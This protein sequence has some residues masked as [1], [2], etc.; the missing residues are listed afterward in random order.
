M[1][2]L[3]LLLLAVLI[4]QFGFWD[5]FSAVLGGVAMLLLLGLLVAGVAVLSGFYAVRRIARR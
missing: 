5:T 4:A 3:I 1:P 2:L